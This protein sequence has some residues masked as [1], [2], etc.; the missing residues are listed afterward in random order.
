M[1]RIKLDELQLAIMKVLWAKGKASSAEV[2]QELQK[3]RSIALT[4]VATV[5]QRLEKK[6]ILGYEK[7]GRQYLYFPLI[8]ELETKSSMVN[9][10]LNQLFQGDSSQLISHLLNESQFDS[11]ELDRLRKEIDDS[12]NDENKGHD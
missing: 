11:N 1:G 9:S 2:T 5:L 6:E 12:F 3:K 10:L 4:T 7:N 8:T